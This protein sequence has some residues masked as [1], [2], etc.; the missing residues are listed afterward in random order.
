M[1]IWATTSCRLAPTWWPWQSMPDESMAAFDKA[2]VYG[3][4][5]Q[6]LPGAGGSIRDFHGRNVAGKL[7]TWAPGRRLSRL[8]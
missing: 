6:D 2:S 8:S 1:P 3:N 4:C 5:D 7:K